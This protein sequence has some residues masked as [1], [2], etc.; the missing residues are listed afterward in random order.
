MV[1]KY[2][3]VAAK[4]SRL[5][6]EALEQPLLEKFSERVFVLSVPNTLSP[7]YFLTGKTVC[8]LK[9]TV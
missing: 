2:Y 3:L 9:A 7:E 1:T 4:K 8:F 5:V 6:T